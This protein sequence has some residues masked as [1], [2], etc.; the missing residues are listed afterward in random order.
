MPVRRVVAN[1]C[2]PEIHLEQAC[3]RKARLKDLIGVVCCLEL[4]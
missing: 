3:M 1:K 2:H 4:S